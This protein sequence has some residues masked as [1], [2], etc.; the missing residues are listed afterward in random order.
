MLLLF[1]YLSCCSP[2]LQDCF[3]PGKYAAFSFVSLSLQSW[4]SE[5]EWWRYAW[6][7]GAESKAAVHTIYNQW[8]R[9]WKM[10]LHEKVL[11]LVLLKGT[12]VNAGKG[13]LFYNI[14]LPPETLCDTFQRV[15]WPSESYFVGF[16]S[17]P[18]WIW[19]WAIFTLQLRI[20]PLV[21][22]L[23]GRIQPT[24]CTL[25]AHGFQYES[26]AHGSVAP[27][28]INRDSGKCS[29]LPSVC[30][31]SLFIPKHPTS[32]LDCCS[33]QMQNGTLKLGGALLYIEIY[34]T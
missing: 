17:I 32:T 28:R 3:S 26:P 20:Q 19:W 6:P 25:K 8:V 11:I 2:E 13:G 33:C 30:P 21:V 23:W 7:C 31:K 24:S 29:S 15:A 5:E 22:K 4:C 16:Q 34:M 1:V 12:S 10:H 9:G 18:V 14:P 27:L